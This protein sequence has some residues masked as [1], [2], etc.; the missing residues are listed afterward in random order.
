MSDVSNVEVNERS[1]V[2]YPNL[3]GIKIG[4]KNSKVNVSKLIYI[5]EQI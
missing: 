3:G 2:E 1:N 4:N 5:E